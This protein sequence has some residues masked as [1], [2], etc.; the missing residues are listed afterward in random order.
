MIQLQS[1]GCS[2]QAPVEV[3]LGP[4]H[5]PLAQLLDIFLHLGGTAC[6]PGP[7]FTP[8]LPRLGATTLSAGPR[9][10]LGFHLAKWRSCKEITSSWHGGESSEEQHHCCCKKHRPLLTFYSAGKQAGSFRGGRWEECRE[11]QQPAGKRLME[12]TRVKLLLE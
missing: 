4:A 10:V 11:R 2:Q 1:C 8:C 3:I 6:V 7:T 9:G 12:P 5:S